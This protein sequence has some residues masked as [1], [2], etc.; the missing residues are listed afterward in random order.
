MSEEY[1]IPEHPSKDEKSY[2]NLPLNQT[3][4]EV[5]QTLCNKFHTSIGNDEHQN[6]V[7]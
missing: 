5:V 3:F 1:A 7:N 6:F 4:Q 2:S